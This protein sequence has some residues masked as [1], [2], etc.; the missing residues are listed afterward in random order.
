MTHHELLHV[1]NFALGNFAL[2]K[3]VVIFLPAPVYDMLYICDSMR[4]YSIENRARRAA[5]ACALENSRW[6]ETVQ[7]APP[8]GALERALALNEPQEDPP[9]APP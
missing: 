7:Y 5:G 2:A 3:V 6:V 8:G 9:E 1:G 4:S